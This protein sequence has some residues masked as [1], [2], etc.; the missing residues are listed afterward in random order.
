LWSDRTLGL[1]LE[2][3]RASDDALIHRGPIAQATPPLGE[4]QRGPFVD[5]RVGVL[6][7]RD[8]P[9]T[10]QGQGLRLDFVWTAQSAS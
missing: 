1:Q 5:L 2:V 6:L 10:I 3:R 8:A 7:P 4:L 9:N